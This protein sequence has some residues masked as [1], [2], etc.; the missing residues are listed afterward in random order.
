MQIDIIEAEL[1]NALCCLKE[2]GEPL[3]GGALPPDAIEVKAEPGDVREDRPRP[4]HVLTVPDVVDR[5]TWRGVGDRVPI[6]DGGGCRP[7][8]T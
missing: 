5:E 7:A 4:R 3:R 6:P 1:V 2:L 8:R